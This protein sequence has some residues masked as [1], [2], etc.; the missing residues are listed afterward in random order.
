MVQVISQTAW[1]AK[2]L[3][4]GDRVGVCDQFTGA[5]PPDLNPSKQIGLGKGHA[6][7]HF[8]LKSAICTKN[9]F[10]RSEPD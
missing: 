10:I 5:L 4:L 9:I 8:G 7:Q 3:L 1:K 2:L 6:I